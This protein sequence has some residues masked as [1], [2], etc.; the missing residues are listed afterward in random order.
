MN[1]KIQ[2][3]LSFRRDGQLSSP[4]RMLSTF[5]FDTAEKP[6]RSYLS[7]VYSYKYSTYNICNN[8]FTHFCIVKKLHF[9]YENIKVQRFK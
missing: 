6:L 4:L 9:K 3:C 5:A 7:Y 8:I 2:Q 1:I